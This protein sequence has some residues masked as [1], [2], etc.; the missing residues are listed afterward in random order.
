MTDDI[1]GHLPTDHAGLNK[2]IIGVICGMKYLHGQGIVHR[3]L[4][5][6]NVLVDSENCPKITD[7]WMSRLEDLGIIKPRVL[8]PDQKA[9][10]L[11]RDVAIH[12]RSTCSPF[13]KC[14]DK[15]PANRLSFATLLESIQWTDC[16]LYGD[17]DNKKL[18][19]F[20]HGITNF[21]SQ[22]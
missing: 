1:E 7:F 12:R 15:K 2:F 11:G 19:A 16:R 14:R 9:S 4:T 18:S 8:S 17:I 13:D 6:R 5:L 21:E 22:L 10:E 3:S 20:A